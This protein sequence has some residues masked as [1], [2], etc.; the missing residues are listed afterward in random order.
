MRTYILTPVEVSAYIDDLAD[1]LMALGEDLPLTWCPVGVS[2]DKIA[3]AIAQALPEEIRNKIKFVRISFR[4]DKKEIQFRE[5]NST[6]VLPNSV[7]LLDGPIHSGSTMANAASWLCS[8]GVKEVISY[9]L[10]VKRST[11][12]VPSF[13]G[14]MIGEHDRAY[15]QFEKIPNHRLRRKG[16]I[17]ILRK[18]NEKDAMSENQYI[19]AG[20][21]SL[22]QI[23]LSDLFYSVTTNS[24]HHVYLYE[25]EGKY[26]GFVH[27]Y[28]TDKITVI[29]DAIATDVNF[30]GKDI[31]GLLMRWVENWA[32]NYRMLEI[33]LYAIEDRLYFY[34]HIGYKKDE[35]RKPI[36]LTDGSYFLMSRR[37]LYNIEPN[38][39][40]DSYG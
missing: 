38:L 6:D 2:G 16:K 39:L 17:G 7:F 40:R 18:I 32:R 25:M 13:F 3:V 15:F 5:D 28:V 27:F 19:Q 9:G 31:G 34:E 35:K 22:S 29:V 12:F 1:R 10:V 14:L 4:R 20:E 24:N 33:N 37:L 8:K 11:E 23:S 30:R 21:N 26:V 36:I